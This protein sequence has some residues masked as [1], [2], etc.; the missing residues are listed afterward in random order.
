MSLGGCGRPSLVQSFIT[1]ERGADFDSVLAA[2]KS[3]LETSDASPDPDMQKP[4]LVTLLL[5]R[6]LTKP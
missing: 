3:N 4:G 2:L 5:E 1:C 6:P